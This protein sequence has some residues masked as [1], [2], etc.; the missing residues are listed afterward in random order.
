[1]PLKGKVCVCVPHTVWRKSNFDTIHLKASVAVINQFAC[2][3]KKLFL[4]TKEKGTAD[5]SEKKFD[6]MIFFV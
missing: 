6:Y 5:E 4:C 3:Q 2:R 1:M